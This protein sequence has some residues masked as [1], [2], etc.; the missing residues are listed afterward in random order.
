MSGGSH[1]DLE[2]LIA[3]GPAV[4]VASVDENGRTEITRGWGL[5]SSRDQYVEVCITASDDSR[6]FSNLSA[7]GQVSVTIVNPQNYSSMQLKG[8]ATFVR[9]VTPDDEAR[10]AE[11]L[12]S[13]GSVTRAI[14]LAGA[15]SLMIGDLKVIGVDVA[16]WFDQTPGVNAGQAI[17]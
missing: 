2:V 12:E 11:H 4:V 3:A 1:A 10:V 7:T 14:G 15:E 16:A 13:F 5:V 9:A 6:M 17:S 8:E